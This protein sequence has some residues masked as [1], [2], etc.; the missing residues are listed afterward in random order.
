ME[1]II[2]IL[3]IILTTNWNRV[4]YRVKRFNI[5]FRGKQR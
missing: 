5:A 3:T 2:L 4:L 1:A